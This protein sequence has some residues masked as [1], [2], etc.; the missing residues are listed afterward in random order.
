MGDEE[1]KEGEEDIK[2]G[3]WSV[4]LKRDMFHQKLGGALPQSSLILIEGKDGFGKSIVS[5]RLL[6]SLLK[7]KAKVTYI[8]TELST[9]DFL[10]QMSSLNYIVDSHIINQDLLF[11][12]MFPYFGKV[13]LEEN[14]IERLL[15]AKQL[16]E[17]DVIIID[18][19]SFLLVRGSISEAKSFDVV[20]FFKK[21]T[22][23]GK[24]VIFTVDPDQL[25]KSLLTLLRSTS[26]IYLELGSSMM[27]G[28]IKKF[29]SVNRF[30]RS[31]GLVAQTI[32]FRVDSG[33]G[34]IIDIAG[35]V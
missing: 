35:L 15:G 9:K 29:M 33:N 3:Y 34:L 21:I 2:E 24:I 18:T 17:S 8:S 28:E 25:N 30:K 6:F 22:N 23:K 16:F 32:A 14:F 27:G 7:A 26:D 4:K 31:S 13:N 12:P 1:K 20:K 11:I 5:Q 10:D 19:I